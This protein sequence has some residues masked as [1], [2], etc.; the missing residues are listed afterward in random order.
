MD[1]KTR[2]LL[3][4]GRDLYEKK[5]YAKAEPLLEQLAASGIKYA[6]VYDMLGVIAQMRGALRDARDLFRKALS[7]NPNYTD[8]LLNL[9]VALNELRDYDGAKEVFDRLNHRSSSTPG[10]IEPFARGKIAN[11]HAE[12]SQAY[13]DLGMLKE[14]TDELERAVA[15]APTFADLR[16]RLGLLYRDGGDLEMARRELAAAVHVNPRYSRA[17]LLLGSTLLALGNTSGAREAW[18]TV[19]QNEPDN[20]RAQSYLKML[21]ESS[22]TRSTKGH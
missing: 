20:A 14:A 18:L 16:V 13:L 8:A 19:L 1:D 21:D 6:D 10:E 11:M 12:I 17:Q 7:I 22:S 3:Q 9:A 5:E 15:L 2:E 4:Q